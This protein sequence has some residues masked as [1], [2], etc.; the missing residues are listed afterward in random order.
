MSGTN[1]FRDLEEKHSN[2]IQNIQNL[3]EIE[4]YMFQNLEK[5]AGNSDSGSQ[6]QAIVDKINE[7]KSIRTGLLQ[8][9]SSLYQDK[10]QD[11]NS[12]RVDLSD[13]IA[14]VGIVESELDRARKNI[15]IMESN[16]TNKLRMAKLYEY[17]RKRYGAYTEV[18]KYIVYGTLVILAL[19]LLIKYNPIGFI[20]PHLYTSLIM[21]TIIVVIILVIR[22][23]SDIN[24]RNNLNF[25]QYD[26]DF[27]PAQYQP[28]YES[29]YQHDVNF[30][31]KLEDSA[32]NYLDNAGSE[33]SSE[34]QAM[35]NAVSNAVSSASREF[36]KV[37]S[38]P[39]YNRS[40][41][42]PPSN[43]TAPATTGTAAG[44]GTSSGISNDPVTVA[45]V[46]GS[47]SLVMPSESSKESFATFN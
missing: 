9:L 46:P 19:M 5:L 31:R 2:T 43:N 7:V 15:G 21:L 10:Q 30:F 14:Q 25:D 34:T 20:T 41:Q 33:I 1:H 36:N 17:E 8:Q 4:K 26:F 24:S 47:S 6:Q 32:E 16:R 22:K 37:I 12:E 11:L 28:G 35:S 3:Q 40:G 13:K 18:M 44:A 23:I 27:D 42:V 29:V 38:D 39:N 45:S